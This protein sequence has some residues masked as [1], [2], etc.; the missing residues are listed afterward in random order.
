MPMFPSDVFTPGY[1]DFWSTQALADFQTGHNKGVSR[2]KLFPKSGHL[3]LSASMDTKIKVRPLL[4][5][6]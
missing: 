5:V 6:I 2:I 3:L 4:V 1:V